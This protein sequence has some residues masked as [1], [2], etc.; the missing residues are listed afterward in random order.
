MSRLLSATALALALPL[1]AQANNVSPDV[2]FGSGNANGSFTINN[3]EST[4]I[5]TIELA[6]RAKLRFD[7]QSSCSA[8]SGAF[9]NIGC[10]QNT[11]NYDGTDTYSFSLANGN[12]PPGY[13]MWNYEWSVS[14]LDGGD[15]ANLAA[16]GAK[17]EISYDIDPTAGTNFQTY[18]VTDFDA[19]YGTLAT[20]NG[21]GTYDNTG[22]PVTGATVAQNSVNYGFIPGAPLGAGTYD[23]ELRLYNVHGDFIGDTGITV[24]VA[25]IP[26]PPALA[27]GA[28]ALGGLGLYARRQ[29][30]ARA[31]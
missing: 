6:L 10:P 1:A 15:I 18:S 17:A 8:F 25:P 2:I 3:A 9:T 5:G 31:A 19:W 26:V 23:I 29:R 16:Q 27:L 14:L 13:A 20:A 30:R 4:A 11:F 7:D 22:T 24:N 12:P 21:G 28:L